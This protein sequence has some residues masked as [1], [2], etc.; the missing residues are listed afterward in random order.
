[1]KLQYSMLF[2][3][4]VKKQGSNQFSS[5]GKVKLFSSESMK[6]FAKKQ[7]HRHLLLLFPPSAASQSRGR[8]RALASSTSGNLR[9]SSSGVNAMLHQCT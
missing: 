1:M 8:K 6:I 2:C 3:I 7:P 5:N 4:F 9:H